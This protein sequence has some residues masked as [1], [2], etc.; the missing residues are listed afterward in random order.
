MILRKPYAFFI[1]IFKPIHIVMS[2]LLMYSI[3]ISNKI[4]NFF[5][6]YIRTTN[7][8]LGEKIT[9]NLI[10]NFLYIIPI[11]LIVFSLIFLGIMYQKKK[12]V[13]FYIVNIF[14]LL[15][16]LIINIYC[17]NFIKIMEKSITP[18]KV[19][20][21]NHDLVL[22][23]MMIQIVVFVILI[24][25]GLGINFKKFNFDSDINKLNISEADKEEFELSINVDLDDA[26]RR[27]KQKIRQ[28]KYLYK[29]NK[30][31]I[32]LMILVF[33]IVISS[34]FIFIKINSTKMNT[35][36]TAYSMNNFNFR[37]NKSI[38]LN[39]SFNGN[40]LTENYLMVVEV[41]L[42][43]NFNQ[44]NLY[45]KDFSLQVED[46]VFNVQT[47]YGEELADLGVLYDGTK[48]SNEYENYIFVFEIPIK[49][50]ESDF[51]FVYNQEGRKHK[52][53]LN[54][55]NITSEKINITKNINEEIKF[56]DTLGEIKFSINSYEMEDKFLLKYNYCISKNDC[57]I[58]KE[59]IK[60]SINE[61]FD[62]TVLKMNVEYVDNSNLKTQKFYKFFSRF[63]SIHYKINNKWYSQ[64]TKFEEI[65]SNR[66]NTKNDVY[67]GI[68]S[69]IK[70]AD[71]VKLVFNIRNAKYEYLLK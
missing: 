33:L 46:I 39:E 58:S 28:L 24:I 64:N 68:N 63:G 66:V 12:P 47:K 19:V 35:E 27:R 16:V 18:I 7:N 44:I 62:K 8:V 52:I 71:S 17:T 37:V 60:P 67:I 9:E 50:T 10:S 65:K 11:I 38:F 13:T 55:Q 69:K 25:R 36:G 59:Y 42:Q 30:T 49:Y 34:I 15:V 53:R 70:D 56:N 32:N 57:I 26:R 61:N 22:I 1:K 2:I 5:S 54:P 23:S 14:S 6:V 45:A 40:K 31:I 48:L 3:Y 51:Y 43:T 29:E 4:L 20:K 41:S 21:L